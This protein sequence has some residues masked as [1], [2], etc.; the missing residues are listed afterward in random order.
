MDSLTT[1]T[2]LTLLTGSNAKQKRKVI[3]ILQQSYFDQCFTILFRPNSVQ[4]VEKEGDFFPLSRFIGEVNHH[5]EVNHYETLSS[6]FDDLSSRNSIH[7]I[8][9]DVH[10]LSD[11][12]LIVEYLP[13]T[14]LKHLHIID[15]KDFWFSYFS[16]HVIKQQYGEELDYTLGEKIT[17]QIEC[18]DTIVVFNHTKISERQIGELLAFLHALQPF[19]II[20]DEHTYDPTFME[21]RKGFAGA[22]SHHMLFDMQKKQAIS[23]CNVRF[24]YDFGISTFLFTR[25]DPIDFSRLEQFLITLPAEVFRMKGKYVDSD[26]KETTFISQVGSSVQVETIVTQEKKHL[27]YLSEFL[28]IG[29]EIDVEQL[30]TKLNECFTENVANQR[31]QL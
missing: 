21:N 12:H 17:E 27:P 16:E 31:K 8:I 6:I 19:A 30:T 1:Q 13:S 7:H 2:S 14:N 20:K 9:V 15:A 10:P 3:E 24:L 25:D 29:S 5:I 28:F 18:A 11:I 26:T 4:V 22:R 23:R